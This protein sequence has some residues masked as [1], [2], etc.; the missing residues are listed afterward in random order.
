MITNGLM[1]RPNGKVVGTLLTDPADLQ[2]VETSADSEGRTVSNWLRK[3]IR[4]LRKRW[5]EQNKNGPG[6]MNPGR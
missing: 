3:E 2:F 6:S 4:K 1:P 5:E